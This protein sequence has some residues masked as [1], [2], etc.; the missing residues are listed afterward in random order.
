MDGLFPKDVVSLNLSLVTGDFNLSYFFVN[1]QPFVAYDFV[2]THFPYF[3][4]EHIIVAQ[5]VR[6]KSDVCPISLLNYD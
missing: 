6:I 3:Y 5:H 4:L 2:I 1:P